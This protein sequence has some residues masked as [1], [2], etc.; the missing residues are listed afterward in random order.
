MPSILLVGKDIRLLSSRAAL[1]S[2][3]QAEVTSVSVGDVMRILGR[4]L[5]DVLIIC[6]TID[7]PEALAITRFA[8]ALDTGICIVAIAH[9]SAALRG[10]EELQV[11]VI[12][13]ADPAHLID[14]VRKLLSPNPE[15]SVEHSA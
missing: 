2:T 10:Y 11:D 7:V 6:H 9:P 12:S 3:T 14:E 1:L 4:R 8:R 15:S 13:E 5:Y